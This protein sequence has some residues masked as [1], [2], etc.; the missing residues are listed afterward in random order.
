MLCKIWGE[1]NM[2]RMETGCAEREKEEVRSRL[3]KR[4][5]FLFT[6]KG[7]IQKRGKLWRGKIR[8]NY[9]V[10]RM[11]MNCEKKGDTRFAED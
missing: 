11:E 10:R 5:G 7:E 9:D 4:R 6:Q 2:V 1:S 8:R 3:K